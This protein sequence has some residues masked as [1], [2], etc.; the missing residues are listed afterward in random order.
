M[1]DFID[2]AVVEKGG[3]FIGLNHPHWQA[4]AELFDLSLREWL[5]ASDE[6]AYPLLMDGELV[7]DDAAEVIYG[8][9]DAMIAQIT[10]EARAIDVERPWMS[11]DAEALDAMSVVDRLALFDVSEL[12]RRFFATTLST[13]V[14]VPADQMSYLAVLVNVKAGGLEAY[15]TDSETHVCVGGSQSLAERLADEIGRSYVHLGR[16]VAA[17]RIDGG[18]V[19][20][21]CLDGSVFEG[22]DVILAIPPSTWARLDIAPALP[23]DL[24]PQMGLVTKY[25][26]KVDSRFWEPDA[27]SEFAQSNGPVSS[28]WDA[29]NSQTGLSQFAFVAFSGGEA[30]AACQQAAAGD[31]DAFYATEIGK[32]YPQFGD[33]FVEGTFVDWSKEIHTN[34]GYSFP[35][36]GQVTELYPRLLGGPH[37]GR[38]HFA[39]EHMSLAF[40]GF[41]EGALESG[42]RVAADLAGRDG[43]VAARRVASRQ[44]RPGR[45]APRARPAGRSPVRRR[46]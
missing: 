31:A 8:E 10:E 42:A 19:T 27:V 34:A 36:P 30:A 24:A 35:S 32:L 29:T 13:P 3:E 2:G 15:W 39:G 28:T 22:D 44:R 4:Y 41:M 17:I 43:L 33:H 5:E 6:L 1:K 21:E 20:V 46:R 7:S 18:A 25:F 26:A 23:A 37:A 16:D 12:G 38:L 45:S 14:G 9:M 40:N 11:P